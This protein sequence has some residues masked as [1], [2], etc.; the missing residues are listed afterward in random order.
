MAWR[1]TMDLERASWSVKAFRWA[2]TRAICPWRATRR[3]SSAGRLPLL[4]KATTCCTRAADNARAR[5][6]LEAVTATSTTEDSPSRVAETSCSATWDASPVRPACSSA[7]D[8][9]VGVVASASTRE[10]TASASVVEVGDADTT[11]IRTDPVHSAA[12]RCSS[13]TTSS[14]GSTALTQI[15]TQWA[16]MM[17]W[18]ISC[19]VI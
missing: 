10:L 16:R 15:T 19:S 5:S 12:L 17:R 14:T 13:T 8:T 7:C 6:G 11:C 18:K 9:K 1:C 2:S 3:S 4:R